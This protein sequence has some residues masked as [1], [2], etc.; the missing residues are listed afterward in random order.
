MANTE[1]KEEVQFTDLFEGLLPDKAPVGPDVAGEDV[2]LTDEQRGAIAAKDRLAERMGADKKDIRVVMQDIA[3]RLMEGGVVVD[4][5]IHRWTGL[6]RLLPKDLGLNGKRQKSDAIKLGEKLLMPPTVLKIINS[7]TVQMRANLDRHSVRTVWGRWVPASAY[8]DWRQRHDQLTEEYLKV[9]HSL[10]DNVDQ[11]RAG[12]GGTWGELRRLYSENARAVWCRMNHYP[13]DDSYLEMCPAHFVDDYVERILDHI[14]GP[15]EIR[16]SFEVVTNISYIPL[17]SMLEEDRVRQQRL[18]EKAADDREAARKR[19][20]AEEQMHADVRSHYIAEKETMI[21]SFLGA[22]SGEIYSRI[23]DACTSALVT[24]SKNQGRLLEPTLRQLHKLLDWGRQM[25]SVLESTEIE[26]ALNDLRAMIGR[27]SELRQPVEVF[28][29]L[30]AMG[31]VA[32]SVLADLDTMP[33]VRDNKVS[34][35]ARDA[36]LG[37]GNRLSRASVAK[38]REQLGTSDMPEPLVV[39]ARRGGEVSETQFIPQL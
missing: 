4:L 17:P 9:G 10:A 15:E 16:D 29:Q 37:V 25:G 7:L 24:S 13:V 30:K 1:M 11:V 8:Q 20:E 39:T 34:I 19:R 33:H 28:D 12:T 14:P 21:D 36:V 18:W 2:A 35:S 3:T 5:D 22:L 31:T 6:K 32:R 38:A 27:S 23:Y 26:T